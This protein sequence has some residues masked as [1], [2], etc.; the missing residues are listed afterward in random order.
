MKA[1]LKAAWTG[2]ARRARSQLAAKIADET[3]QAARRQELYTRLG[4]A[5]TLEG[6]FEMVALHAGLVMRRLSALGENGGDLAQVYVDRIFSGFD[7]ALREMAIGDVGVVKRMRRYVEA[8]YG[9]LTA[10]D[11]ALQQPNV[12]VFAE[13]LARNVYAESSL[14]GAPHALALAE[15]AQGVARALQ[16]VTF[17]D[18]AQGRFAF[19]KADIME[20]AG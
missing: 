14:A 12:Q 7:D 4:V 8:F 13:A 11:A 18:F 2:R 5:D 10:Y 20:P 9:R 19:P 15:Y 6:R 1:L 16:A 17:D 3:M